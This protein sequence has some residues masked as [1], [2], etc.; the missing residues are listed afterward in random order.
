MYRLMIVDDD[1]IL[2]KGLVQ[3]VDWAQYG[4]EVV[5]EAKNGKEALYKMDESM[6]Q[7]IITDIQMPIMDGLQLTKTISKLYPKVKIVLLTAYEEFEYA[8]KALE[9]RVC[10]YVLKYESDEAVL[11]AVQSA[12]KQ[13]EAETESE[14]LKEKNLE[15][16]RRSFFREISCN[17]LER[18]AIEEQAQHL[19]IDLHCRRY[20]TVSFKIESLKSMDEIR[21]LVQTK[22]WFRAIEE[23]IGKRCKEAGYAISFFQGKEYLNG[24]LLD[25]QGDNGMEILNLLQ[26]EILKLQTELNIHLYAG[27]GRWYETIDHVHE[28][29]MEA[30]KVNHLRDIL[31]K[32]YPKEEYPVLGY[33]PEM[34]A[35]ETIEELVVKVKGYIDDCYAREELSLEEIAAQVHLS[36]NYVSTL[37]K[38]HSGMNISDYIIKVRMEHAARL[39]ADTNFK[40]YEIAEQI[41][42]TNAQYFSVLF[43]KYYKMTP[44]EYR[45][46]N[47]T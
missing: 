19:G 39:L 35:E 33:R 5:A 40:T 26:H 21:F 16:Q 18:M 44:K 29:Y 30:L 12:V 47:K 28:S 2:R 42:Y 31:D 46:K 14:R 10:Q 17:K 8:K 24:V 25:E 22:E 36:A 38:K 6:P 9:Y 34:S 45:N 41:G 27:M 13:I 43:K 23:T 1:E 11:E 7:I 37:F 20:G 3:K 32:E 4:L 15:A